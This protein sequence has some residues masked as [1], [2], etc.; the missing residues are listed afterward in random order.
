MNV[1][2]PSGRG[3]RAHST[4]ALLVA[5]CLSVLPAARL[6]A[7]QT[8]LTIYNDGRVFARRSLPVAVPKGESTQRVTPGSLDPGSLLALDSGITILDA[9]YDSVAGEPNVLRRSLGRTF[10]FQSQGFPSIPVAATL[11]GVDPERWRLTDGTVL[12]Q[13]PGQIRWPEDLTLFEPTL[14]LRLRAAQARPA[15]ALGF[16]TA[17]AFWRANYQVFLGGANV[18]VR[19][20]AVVTSQT[21]RADSAEIQLLAGSVRREPTLMRNELAAVGAMQ[22]KV[23]APQGATEERVEESHVYTLP[24]R[25]SLRPGASSVLPVFEETTAPVTREYVVRREPIFGIYQ[26]VQD[27]EQ[28]PVQVVYTLARARKTPFG[29]R[30]LPAGTARLFRPDG[31][32]RLQLVGEATLDHTPAG[33]ELVLRAGNAF[34]L[35]ARRRQTDFTTT[36]DS[37]AAGIRTRAEATYEVALANATDSAAAVIVEEARG[38]EWSV[39]S[40]SVAADKVS[41]TVT[42]F[43][44]P[45]PARG[46][47][48]LTYRIRV[49]W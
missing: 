30:P 38:G 47:A 35:T 23:M 6:P 3:R 8:S 21:L 36:R 9:R 25:W 48:K 5:G 29:E 26:E 24:G 18:R 32:G 19:G 14:E 7:Q 39:L 40:S 17:G 42:R 31:E 16:F 27:P 1:T 10:T 41:S 20:V 44:V 2:G 4:T 46:E 34:D 15:L 28:V 37:S 45:V 22:R 12:F 13:R 43:R 49:I 33:K 11:V